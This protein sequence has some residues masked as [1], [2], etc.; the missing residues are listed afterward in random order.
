M[1]SRGSYVC[2]FCLA[3]PESLRLRVDTVIAVH[4]G[5]GKMG[6]GHQHETFFSPAALLRVS[7]TRRCAAGAS[8]KNKRLSQE[9]L[10][11]CRMQKVRGRAR[12]TVG[13]A[14]AAWSLTECSPSEPW[15]RRSSFHR[16]RVQ[17]EVGMRCR[18]VHTC[19][20]PSLKSEC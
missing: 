11:T 5:D 20:P 10:S 18:P 2:A 17:M 3:V 8:K 6:V 19:M 12:E 16:V 13:R 7:P 15:C 9:L 4:H 1:A 14:P